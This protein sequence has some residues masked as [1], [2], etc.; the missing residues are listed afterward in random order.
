MRVA[1][2]DYGAG[3][4]ASVVKALRAVGADVEIAAT[5]AALR[6][7]GTIV[8]PGVGHF[9]AT[10]TLDEQWRAVVRERLN[11]GASLLGIC[12]GMQWLFDGSAEAPGLPGL[13][14]FPGHCVR[15]RKKTSGV[16]SG[17]ISD[18]A[19]PPPKDSSGKH[20]ETPKR[21]R[22]SFSPEKTPDVFLRGV[23]VPH[24]GWNTLDFEGRPP[25]LD[26]LASGAYA[27]FTHA[28][29]APVTDDTIATTT[30]GMTFASVVAR[31]RV[32]GAQWH[33]EKSGET[34]LQLLRNFMALAREAR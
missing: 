13:G 7:A 2:V 31:G 27:Y 19:T 29:A 18:P 10:R 5:P 6:D 25:L 24:V 23:K 21:R 11:A 22:V 34:G 1:L 20:I 16:F 26:G 3:N 32:Y 28:Y 15:F 14:V 30:H 4:L 8:V 12:L 9:E 33:P 17:V